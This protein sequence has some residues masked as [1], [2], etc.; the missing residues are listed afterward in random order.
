[1]GFSGFLRGKRKLIRGECI[2]C[3]G[4]VFHTKEMGFGKGE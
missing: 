1:M 2:I 3:D 4:N